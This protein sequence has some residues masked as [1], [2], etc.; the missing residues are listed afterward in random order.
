MCARLI[1]VVDEDGRKVHA[2]C[3]HAGYATLCAVSIDDDEEAGREAPP[4]KGDKIDCR[5]CIITIR[6]AKA[7]RET[8]FAGHLRK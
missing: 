5:A 7:Y 6:E 1:A 3:N 4:A 2:R 8:D